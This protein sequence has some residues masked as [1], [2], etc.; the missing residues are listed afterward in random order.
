M[1]LKDIYLTTDINGYIWKQEVK[2][3]D[4]PR[5]QVVAYNF[6]RM[7]IS[8]AAHFITQ[9]IYDGALDLAGHVTFHTTRKE[10]EDSFDYSV[11]PVGCS[12]R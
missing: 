11:I 5:K 3:T 1:K 12:K 6:N 2:A 4:Y 10:L 7:L 9:I 8:A